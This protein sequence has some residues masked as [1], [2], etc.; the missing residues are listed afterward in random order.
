MGTLGARNRRAEN[1]LVVS[2]RFSV[3]GFKMGRHSHSPAMPDVHHI[4][5]L[6]DVILA[7]KAQ[8]TLGSGISF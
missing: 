5:V 8:R 1:W 6:H 7:F 3:P 4:A 2:S